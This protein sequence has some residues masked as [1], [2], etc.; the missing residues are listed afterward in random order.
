MSVIDFL[1]GRPERHVVVAADG[2]LHKE[3]AVRLVPARLFPELDRLQG[4]A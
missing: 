4:A 2:E 3:V 1:V